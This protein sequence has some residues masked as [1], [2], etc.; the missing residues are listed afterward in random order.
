MSNELLAD[1]TDWLDERGAAAAT[2][3]VNHADTFLR[4][5][6]QASLESLNEHDIRT[7]LLWCP[8][9]FEVPAEWAGEMCEAIVEFSLFL[10][11]MGRLRGG[12]ERGRS[13]PRLANTLERA[14]CAAIADQ[15]NYAQRIRRVLASRFL[16]PTS[17]RWL[18]LAG[19]CR[20]ESPFKSESRCRPSIADMVD[21]EEQSARAPPWLRKN[22]SPAVYDSC[23]TPVLVVLPGLDGKDEQ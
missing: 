20:R 22:V 13:P 5:R 23:G 17:P 4:W 15:T 1:F 11:C 6:A 19:S 7:F 18:I 14:V 9:H 2:E 16:H 12:R 10:V 3:L 8:R 21:A